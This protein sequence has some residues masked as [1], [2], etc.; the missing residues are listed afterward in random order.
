MSNTTINEKYLK[1]FKILNISIGITVRKN[2]FKMIGLCLYSLLHMRGVFKTQITFDAILDPLWVKIERWYFLT[3]PK[4][5][6]QFKP[7]KWIGKTKYL[8]G[9]QKFRIF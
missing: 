3:I 8:R 9:E 6:D 5:I 1:H 4:N 7:I 2:L